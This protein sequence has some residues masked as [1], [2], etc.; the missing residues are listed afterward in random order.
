MGVLHGRDLLSSKYNTAI[1][2]D[3][4]NRVFFVPIKYVIGDYFIAE[5][6]KLTY[7]FKLDGTR[8][9]EY[10]AGLVKSFRVVFYD[11][12]HYAA[13]S[14]STKEVELALVINHLPKVDSMLFNIFKI[15]GSREK[16]P[17]KKHKIKDLKE[18]IK[19]KQ[20]E[21]DN[22]DEFEEEAKSIVA[23]LDR[24]N[25]TQIVTPVKKISEFLEADL[26]TTQPQFLGSILT[27]SLE[28]ESEHRKVTNTPIGSKS[29]WLK[30]V[31]VMLLISL[32][33][34]VMYMAYDGGAFDGITGAVGGFGDFDF[35]IGGGIPGGGTSGSIM[36]KY[37][38]P[39]ALKLAIDRGDVVYN[40]LPDDI[41][42]LVDGVKPVTS[43]PVP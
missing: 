24:L 26:L 23:Y 42:K 10:R 1:I 33:G 3:A 32:I 37:P 36:D 8:K 13:I 25:V 43:K 28:A 9:Y 11:L 4:S 15:L 16:N 12:S 7:V 20:A 14:P 39:E 6:E 21:S 27:A 22:P 17:F 18:Y 34:V 40:T 2:T 38:T 5:I 29:A 30:W 41:K 35:N 19:R 31:A